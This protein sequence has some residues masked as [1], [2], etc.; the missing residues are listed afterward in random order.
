MPTVRAAG[1]AFVLVC[2]T[3]LMAG[4][5]AAA[6]SAS[7]SSPSQS[8]AAS[9]DPFASQA[10]PYS[11][12]RIARELAEPP[13]KDRLRL[14]FHVVVVGQAPPPALFTNFDLNRG[15]VPFGAPTQQ[16]FLDVVTPEAFKAPAIDLGGLV[17]WFAHRVKP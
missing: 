10:V 11:V 4:S 14:N 3:G 17:K 1:R 8:T 13:P 16:Q 2:L 5:S 6:Q 9:Q 12:A 15:P 7:G